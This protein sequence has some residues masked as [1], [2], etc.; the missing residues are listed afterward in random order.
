MQVRC[1]ENSLRGDQMINNEFIEVL[2]AVNT[3][4]I[5]TNTT[6]ILYIGYKLI[7]GVYCHVYQKR[8]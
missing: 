3:M 1:I 6:V 5:L 8:N 2:V 7:K 4:A